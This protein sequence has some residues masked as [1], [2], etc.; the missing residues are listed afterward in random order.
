MRVVALVTQMMWPIRD[1]EKGEEAD[2]NDRHQSRAARA[3]I[4]YELMIADSRKRPDRSGRRRFD[5]E[6]FHHMMSPV[7]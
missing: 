6:R 5:K 7:T 4:H 3:E 1:S 2:Q